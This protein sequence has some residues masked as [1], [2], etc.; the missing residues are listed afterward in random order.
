[1]T[2]KTLHLPKFTV[3]VNFTRDLM[4]FEVEQR[5]SK[6]KCFFFLYSLSLIGKGLGC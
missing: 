6:E 4:A 1:M 5:E 2:Q 3:S